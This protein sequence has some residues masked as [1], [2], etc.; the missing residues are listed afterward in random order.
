MLFMVGVFCTD[1]DT[2]S[3]SLMLFIYVVICLNVRRFADVPK[4]NDQLPEATSYETGLMTKDGGFLSATR[5]V[6]NCF[7]LPERL[8]KDT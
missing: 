4:S 8:T 6:N 3:D 2:D 7:L 5:N 1:T